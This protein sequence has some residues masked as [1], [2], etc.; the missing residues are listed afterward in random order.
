MYETCTSDEGKKFGTRNRIKGILGGIIDEDPLGDC[1][2]SF[3]FQQICSN[4]KVVNPTSKEIVS[5]FSSLGYHIVQTYYEPKLWKTDAS[6]ETVYDVIRSYKSTICER[7]KSDIMHNIHEQSC[8][9]RILEKPLTIK[10][11]FSYECPAE[12]KQTKLRKYFTPTEPNWGPKARAT[13]VVSK[14]KSN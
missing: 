1:A 3:D 9:R 4:L 7:E 6:P 12:E 5:G 8:M 2:L 10:P 14:D 11:N 13:G